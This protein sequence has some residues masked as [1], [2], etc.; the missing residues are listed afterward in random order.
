MP[1]E[2]A[3]VQEA[4]IP[5]SAEVVDAGMPEEGAIEEASPEYAADFEIASRG[6]RLAFTPERWAAFSEEDRAA[7]EA[8][9]RA[10]VGADEAARTL[11]SKYDK[12]QAELRKIEEARIKAEARAETLAEVQAR[13]TRDP[14]QDAPRWTVEQIA[15]R[16]MQIADELTNL[17]YGDEARRDELKGFDRA[18]KAEAARTKAWHESRARQTSE[19]QR[20]EEASFVNPI[21][22][23][24]EMLALERFNDDYAAWASQQVGVPKP[25]IQDMIAKAD[26]HLSKTRGVT[27]LQIA[28]D[29]QLLDQRAD[30][31]EFLVENAKAN[32]IAGTTNAE[33]KGQGGARAADPVR[34]P[35]SGRSAGRTPPAPRMGQGAMTGVMRT[36]SRLDTG[37][38]PLR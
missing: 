12:T 8:F 1:P 23:H 10:G 3:E 34:L 13:S 6:A 15:E 7:I 18:L 16:R 35:S 22:Y 20:A 28:K 4:E 14:E 29:R 17:G 33:S 21:A 27:P 24:G 2:F 25:M 9:A 32:G 19:K 31:I 11:Q 30:F 38:S 37:L 26:A 36:I 5:Q